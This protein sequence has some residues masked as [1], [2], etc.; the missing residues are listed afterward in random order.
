VSRLESGKMELDRAP[1]DLVE[2][3]RNA[4]ATLRPLAAERTLEHFK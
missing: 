2:I 3:A 4:I 1:A